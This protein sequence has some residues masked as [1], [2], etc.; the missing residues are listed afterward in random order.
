MHNGT[1][2][3]DGP[4]NDILRVLEVDDN[5]FGR[6]IVIYFLTNADVVVGF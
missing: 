5:N 1:V 4:A 6:G 2:G 3:L